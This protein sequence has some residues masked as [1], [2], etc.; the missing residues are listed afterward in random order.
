M[1]SPELFQRNFG[2]DG[3]CDD[4]SS[5][6]IDREEFDVPAQV[7]FSPPKPAQKSNTLCWEA[8]VITFNGTNV[9]GSSN[10]RNVATTFQNGWAD[11][12]IAPVTVGSR[13]AHQLVLPSTKTAL[14]GVT[15]TGQAT[16]VGLPIIGFAVESFNNGTLTAPGLPGLIQSNYGGN[17]V[18]KTKRSILGLP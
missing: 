14:T 4:I 17:F 18:H 2:A 12:A 6:L 3:A 16:Y 13:T 15:T 11:L 7:V 8:N 10:S 5:L 1:R 9:L